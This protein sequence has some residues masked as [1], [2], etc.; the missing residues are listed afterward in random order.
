MTEIALFTTFAT[1][2]IT[3]LITLIVIIITH[4]E[5]AHL[6]REIAQ[7]KER[8]TCLREEV[9]QLRKQHTVQVVTKKPVILIVQN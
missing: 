9:E 1:E 4:Q 7:A 6:E 2:I 3:S 5:R 8:N